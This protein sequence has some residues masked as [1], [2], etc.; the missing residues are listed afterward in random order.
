M[1]PRHLVVANLE[2]RSR[3][4]PSLPKEEPGVVLRSDDG[5]QR[6][7]ATNTD[8]HD[9]TPED[10]D[11]NDGDSTRVGGESLGESGHDDD[12]QLNTVHALTTNVIR[13][14]TEEELTNH[15][16]TGGRDLDRSVGGGGDLAGVLGGILPEDNTEHAGGQ[17]DGEDIIGVG[18]E[19]NTSDDDGT[20]MI[21]TELGI[22]NLGEGQTTA[23][24]GVLDMG[25]VVVV[26]AEGRVATVSESTSHDCKLYCLAGLPNWV[27]LEGG[28]KYA[29]R[30]PEEAAWKSTPYKSRLRQSSCH[31]DRGKQCGRVTESD[32]SSPLLPRYFFFLGVKA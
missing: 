1:A 18:E 9:D 24:N 8:T 17:V 13:Q 3:L 25:E 19:T 27:F 16:T 2:T 22:V 6:V 21:P 29:G 20:N 5:R 23:L 31:G 32:W 4:A 26:V 28:R 11:T 14:V 10:E 7:V 15:R 30:I 12:D